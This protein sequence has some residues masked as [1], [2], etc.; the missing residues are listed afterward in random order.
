[1]HVS[2]AVARAVH[3]SRERRS[4]QVV[5]EAVDWLITR[6]IISN[7]R[8]L[9]Q[10]TKSGA[11]SLHGLPNVPRAVVNLRKRREKPY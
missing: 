10:H 2:P 5:A 7:Q 1:M 11:P 4:S 9:I 6:L 8:V 3:V